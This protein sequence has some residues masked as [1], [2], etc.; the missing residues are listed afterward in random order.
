[1]GVMIFFNQDVLQRDDDLLQIVETL[2]NQ[3][4]QYIQRK[5]V[6]KALQ[7]EREKTEH[8]LLNILPQSIAKRLKQEMSTIA[9]QFAEVSVLFADLVG[10]TEMAS[11]W[12]PIELVGLLNEIFS[13]FDKLTE[14][15]HLEKIK[16]IGDAYMVVSGLPEPN[17]QH[18]SAIANM[19]LDM[20]AVMVSFNKR[21]H[22]NLSIRVGVHSGPVVAGVIGLKKFIYD[23]WGDTVNTASRMESH[24]LA[25]HI[26]VSDTTYKLL[27]TQYHFEKRG[28]IPV[29][30]K[31]NMTTYF[32]VGKV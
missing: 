8:L 25:D 7:F 26:Q 2:G 9:E 11:T 17:A 12:S 32:L 14:E 4:G 16:T 28:L 18:A 21:Y 27:K 30:G 23:L 5:R 20:Q 6:E 19:A 22:K 29:K 3:L 10:F 15:H 31:G 1:L 13:A 24:G